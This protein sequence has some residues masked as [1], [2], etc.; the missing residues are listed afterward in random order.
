MPVGQIGTPVVKEGGCM[1]AAVA[2][3]SP[4]VRR[5]LRDD[6]F[7]RGGTILFLLK[8]FFKQTL[9]SSGTWLVRFHGI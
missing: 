8:I 4:G 2:R 7:E 6:G 5:L 1:A 3:G 9:A